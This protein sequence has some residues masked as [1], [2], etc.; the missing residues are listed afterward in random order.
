MKSIK[1]ENILLGI[2]IILFR[3]PSFYVLPVA[4]FNSQNIGRLI[5]LFLAIYILITK[6]K[7]KGGKNGFYIAL[8]FFFTLSISILSAVNIMSF[9][10]VYKN[11]ALSFLLFYSVVNL[12]DKKNVKFYLG[13]LSFTVFVNIIFEMIGYFLPNIINLYKIVLNENYWQYFDYELHRNKY[14][15]DSYNELILPIII[16][17]FS[18]SKSIFY[19]VALILSIPLVIFMAIASNWRVK[20]I[21]LI[22]EILMCFVVYRDRLKKYYLF[23]LVIGLIITLSISNSLSKQVTGQN[24]FDRIVNVDNDSNIEG[25][26][27]FWSQATLMGRVSFFGIGLGNFYDNLISNKYAQQRQFIDTRSR[28]IN[29]DAHNIFFNTFA[30]TGLPGLIS[31]FIILVYFL[32]SDTKVFLKTK[33]YGL[34]SLIAAFWGLIVFSLVDTTSSFSYISLFW[35]LRAMILSQNL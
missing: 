6:N 20:L 21:A 17:Q 22:F 13:I 25:R 31:L 12:V 19:K 29:D 15:G 3:L 2:V 10:T 4:L 28:V 5:I 1:F 16:F 27:M 24:T 33:Y 11:F 9:L 23:I 35:L 14:F 26:F 34:K 32:F 7:K 30:T 8:L 18:N